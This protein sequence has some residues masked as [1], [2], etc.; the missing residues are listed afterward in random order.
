[1]IRRLI[2]AVSGAAFLVGF[3]FVIGAP[4]AFAACH[5]FTVKAAPG[6]ANEGQTVTV[7]VTRD[8]AVNPSSVDVSSIDGTAKSGQDF[9]AVKRKVEFTA[10]T[11]QSFTFVISDDTSPEPEESFKLHLSNAGGC[12]INPNFDYGEDAT[13]TI[14]ANDT[15][16]TTAPATP[17]TRAAAE[18]TTTASRTTPSSVASTTAPDETTSTSKAAVPADSSTTLRTEDVAAADTDDDDSGSTG[19]LIA[20]LVLFAA[21][22]AAGA[23]LFLRRRAR[24]D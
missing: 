10:E 5:A 2:A 20:A 24:P 1:M 4:P 19:A 13:V 23:Y 3:L 22:A 18:P 14:A 15:S 17:T 9:P 11:S 12:A 7:T 8:A 21:A 16:N 6:T